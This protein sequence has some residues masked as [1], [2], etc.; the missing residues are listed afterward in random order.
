ME[1]LVLGQHMSLAMDTGSVAVLRSLFLGAVE[2]RQSGHRLGGLT[3][4]AGAFEHLDLPLLIIA[5]TKDDLAP[6]ASVHPAFERSMASDKTYRAFPQGHIDLI[7]GRDAP[8]TIWP[9]IEAWVKRRAQ[10]EVVPGP[11][12]GAQRRPA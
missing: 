1:P 11:Q 6:P 3:G 9:L 10:A 7:M 8:H 2:Q 5:G 4:Y 12:G